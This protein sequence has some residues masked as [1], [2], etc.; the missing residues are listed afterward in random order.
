MT[1][2]HDIFNRPDIRGE[3]HE[4]LLSS[5]PEVRK[6]VREGIDA[7]VQG[8]ERLEA[9]EAES[10]EA[11]GLADMYRREE[12]KERERAASVKGAL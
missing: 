8:A 1:V 6:F 12:E 3:R 11:S 9:E 4:I 10:L 2:K 5:S 7:I